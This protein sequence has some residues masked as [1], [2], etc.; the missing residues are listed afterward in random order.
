MILNKLRDRLEQID[1]IGADACK[2]ILEV[3]EAAEGIEIDRKADDS[4]LTEAD[5]R[6]NDCIVDGLIELFPEI[7]I[8]SEENKLLDY[9]ERKRYEYHWLVDPLDGTKEFIRRNGEF[10]V[11]IA[12]IHNGKSVAGFVWVPVT[13]QFYY[14]I[15]GS[16]SFRKDAD[17]II[18][19]QANTLTMDDTG[20]RVVASRSH[21]N[22]ETQKLLDKLNEPEIVSTGSSLKFLKIAE[23]AA[24]FYPRV[25]PTM[26]WDT[27]AAQIILEEAG[28][29][30]LRYEDGVP[31]R[32]GKE[33]LLNPFFIA[34]GKA[35]NLQW[36]D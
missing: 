32:Y 18:Q 23:G 31:L 15:E 6:A 25:A 21:L 19:L 3:Y 4:P 30:V 14:A 35:D 7:P 9:E 33:N 34:H 28:G 16:G 36:N 29:K 20:L 5:R 11:N 2:V 10:T 12:L 13:G 1:R 26:E 27:G 8:V 24:D 22:E 17:S